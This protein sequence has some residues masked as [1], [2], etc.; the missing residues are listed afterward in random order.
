MKTIQKVLAL[1]IATLT[2]SIAFAQLNLG[3]QSTTNAAV[4]AS[5][6]TAVISQTTSSISNTMR[7]T[8]NATVSKAVDVKTT[9]TGVVNAGVNRASNTAGS[10]K[11]EIKKNAD[12]KAGAG[13]PANTQANTG[14]QS[15]LGNMASQTSVNTNSSGNAG[16]AIQVNGSQVID[17]TDNTSARVI[18]SVEN[19]TTAAVDKGRELKS[20]TQA[21]LVAGVKAAKETTTSVKPATSVAVSAEAK[22][23][24]K[25]TVNKQ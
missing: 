23:E 19:K 15:Q 14:N 22:T 13:I 7:T 12:L 5:A 1:F 8:V 21:E 10:V 11:N 16:V 25:A 4:N 3:L 2:T 24:T 17:K 9:T 20:G 6:Q 18:T